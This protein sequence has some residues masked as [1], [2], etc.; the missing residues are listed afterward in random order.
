MLC[1]GEV[2]MMLA[3]PARLPA[4]DGRNYGGKQDG[5]KCQMPEDRARMLALPG[6]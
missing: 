6:K 1:E 4:A 3:V 5:C 2:G